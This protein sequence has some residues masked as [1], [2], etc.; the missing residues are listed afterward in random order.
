M[1][2]S[3]TFARGSNK[4]IAALLQ[5]SNPAR[6]EVVNRADELHIAARQ[7]GFAFVCVENLSNGVS[8]VGLDGGAQ[9]RVGLLRRVELIECGQNILQQH[10]DAAL[11][12]RAVELRGDPGLYGP[13]SFVP[14]D[15]EERSVKVCRRVL[16]RAE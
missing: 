13:A 3:T 8:H 7:T 9:Q 11:V 14:H 1:K 12:R 10:L 16:Q 15:D 6:L 2:Y 5:K 4:R